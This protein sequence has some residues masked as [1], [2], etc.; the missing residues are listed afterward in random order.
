MLF[1]V[2]DNKLVFS[3]QEG[4]PISYHST[5]TF[6]PINDAYP[7]S[8]KLQEELSQRK[9]L[10]TELSVPFVTLYEHYKEGYVQII[11]GI[12]KKRIYVNVIV[13]EIRSYKSLEH[14]LVIHVKRCAFIV[15]LAL[16]WGESACAHHFLFGVVLSIRKGNIQLS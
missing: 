10:L 14:F 2:E 4:Q 5:Y 12:N 1:T 15:V 6:Y 7:F 8:Q 11:K 16:E 9:L 3:P 13:V